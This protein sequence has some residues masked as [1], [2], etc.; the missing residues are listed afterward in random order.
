MILAM[1]RVMTLG[2]LRDRGALVLAFVL[3][4]AIFVIFASIFSATTSDKLDLKVAVAQ[5]SSTPASQ[6]LEDALRQEPTFEVT[7]PVRSNRADVESLVK[8]GAADVGLV[9]RGEIDDTDAAPLEVLIEP[10]KLMAGSIVSGRVQELVARRLPDLLLSRT[11][12]T[13]QSVVGAFTPEQ[14]ARLAAAIEAGARVSEQQVSTNAPGLVATASVG[15]SGSSGATVSYYAGAVAILFLLFA[16]LQSAATLIEE[17]N[18]GIIDRIAV[19]PGGSAVVV[20]GKLL[21]LTIQGV[22]QVGLIFIVAQLVYEVDV[23]KRLDLWLLITVAAALGASGLA[24]AVATACTTKQ[25]AQTVSTFVVLICSA[26]GGSMVPRFMMP[27]FLQAIGRF[28]PNTWAIEAYY[29]VFWRH[30]TLSDVI[31]EIVSLV[32]MAVVGTAFALIVSRRRL[33]F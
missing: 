19:G 14:S 23:I 18:S 4:P 33:R 7:G 22:I 15:S 21:F 5:L 10:S 28:T 9:I 2:L 32:A 31:P 29:G 17:R 30:E 26:I 11:A 12:V 6:R 13:F 20:L 16:S 24:L 1:L 8:Q 3:P 27:E 25:Q